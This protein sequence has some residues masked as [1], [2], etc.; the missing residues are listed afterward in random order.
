MTF[1]IEAGP[2]AA[3]WCGDRLGIVISGPHQSFGIARDGAL[4]GAAVFQNWN[5]H[6]IDV[7]VAGI[8]ASWPRAFLR[9]LGH[10]AFNELNCCRVTAYTRADNHRA[11][12]VLRKFATHEG[13]KR[14]GY[15]SCDALIFGILKEEWPYGC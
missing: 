12:K 2:R 8:G 5:H 9:R 10:Y 11:V 3:E 13:T 7:A 1:T 15:G 14:K 6:D 4:F